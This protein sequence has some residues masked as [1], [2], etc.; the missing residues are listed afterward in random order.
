MSYRDLTATINSN[1]LSGRLT[2]DTTFGSL[3]VVQTTS[4]PSLPQVP[5]TLGTGAGKINLMSK[6]YTGTLTNQS[7]FQVDLTAA[8]DPYNTTIN[9]ARV[10][11]LLVVNFSQAGNLILGAAGLAPAA[12][13]T[14]S[15]AGTDG[16]L[17]AGTYLV[18]YTLLNASGESLRSADATQVVSGTN[19][20]TVTL[21]TLPTGATGRNIY[22]STAG[23]NRTTQTKNNVGAVSASSYDI[24]ANVAGAAPPTE[25]TC[26]YNG[27]TKPFR[28]KASGCLVI[29]PG[30]TV[31]GT[32]YINPVF[33]P[34]G[35]A[36]G[37]PV[38]GPNKLLQLFA[39][40]ADVQ[41]GLIIL[42][43]DA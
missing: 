31:S 43:N 11:G 37:Y 19:H 30:W 15:V 35:D 29:N 4:I 33:I 1:F 7:Q 42:G 39:D 10:K 40:G 12:A 13:P 34:C 21:G 6:F 26:Y 5:Y 17:A 36:T 8:L 24:V 27:F 16:S 22:V 2:P 3:D 41:Y 38:S 14:L 23:G 18:S 9:F 20:I 32:N 25:N 28:D